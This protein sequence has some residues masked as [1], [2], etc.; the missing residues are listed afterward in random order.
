LKQ[1]MAVQRQHFSILYAARLENTQAGLVFSSAPTGF[2]NASFSR[3]INNHRLVNFHMRRCLNNG[4]AATI[5]LHSALLDLSHKSEPEIQR[6][7]S[8]FPNQGY[9]K[10]Q[11]KREQA[12]YFRSSY[13]VLQPVRS[14]VSVG[15]VKGVIGAGGVGPNFISRL[16]LLFS[17]P[18]RRSLL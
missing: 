11:R 2:A 5:S 14:V 17:I 7:R 13:R 16:S 8:R 9:T 15:G 3:Y 12:S 18:L 4:R 6:F 1:D 10:F